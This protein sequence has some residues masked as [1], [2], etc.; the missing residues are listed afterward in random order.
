MIWAPK[1]K[2]RVEVS[3]LGTPANVKQDLEAQMDIFK[4]NSTAWDHEVKRGSPWTQPVSTE[5]VNRAR[6][7]DFKIILTPTKPVPK[8]WLGDF[9]GK[10]VLCLA[11]GGGQQGPLLAAA[12][13]HVV[14]LDA[15]TEQLERDRWVAA[16]DHLELKTV[17][18]DMRDLS[19]FQDGEFDLIV[20]P[21][22]NCFIPDV[23]PVWRECF[24]VLKNRGSLLSGFNNPISYC[25]DR[26]LYDEGKLQFKWS[27]PY[28]DLVALTEAE[29]NEFIAR[30]DPFEFGHT[31]EDQIG[32]QIAAG[33]AI[34]GFYEDKW[35]SGTLEDKFYPHFMASWAAKL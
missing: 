22:S 3:F 20:H 29:Q 10:Q 6:G 21:V 9:S 32:G 11:S 13:A 19:L 5:E 7:G 28:S 24:R 2:D 12:G 4:H 33:F 15:S 26:A 27:V 17:L 34:R 14:V 8:E 16:R 35:G 1:S 30:H 25:F 31:L 18:G 23:K